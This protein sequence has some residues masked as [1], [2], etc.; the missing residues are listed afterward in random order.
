MLPTPRRRHVFSSSPVV[1]VRPRY[2][3]NLGAVAR[4]LRVFGFENL[5]LVDPHPLA[6]PALENAR[7]L[8]VGAGDI[9]ERAKV[10]PSVHELSTEILVATTSRRGVSGVLSP[11]ELALA[12]I[13]KLVESQGVAL[14]FGGERAGLRKAE[15]DLCPWVCRI[16]MAGNQPSVNLAQ[17]VTILLYELYLAALSVETSTSKTAMNGAS[18]G[19]EQ[20]EDVEGHGE[21]KADEEEK[22]EDGSC[23]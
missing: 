12:L 3:E 8:A 17:A 16:P 19:G 11:R 6:D 4:A 7:K 20:G 14:V 2:P 21:G 22:A 1:L 5:I 23:P 15:V 18:R 13:E 9:L 10:I